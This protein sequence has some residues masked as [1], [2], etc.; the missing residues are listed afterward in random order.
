M[1]Q[2]LIFEDNADQLHLLQSNIAG[3]G[4]KILVARDLE[5]AKGL[6]NLRPDLVVAGIATRLVWI[7]GPYCGQRCGWP[8]T[9][10]N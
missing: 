8:S 6:L 9:T 10:A 1:V 2:V 7:F 3:E 4:R 5:Q